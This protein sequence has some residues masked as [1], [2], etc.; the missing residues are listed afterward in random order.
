MLGVRR[1]SV[2]LVAHT[3][4]QAGIIKYTRGKTTILNLEGMQDAAC[5]CYATVIL[6]LMTQK[7]ARKEVAKIFGL[8]ELVEV[9]PRTPNDKR[10]KILMDLQK[11]ASEMWPSRNES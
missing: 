1:T 4:Q 3:L 8:V 2:T 9:H 11:K 6:H 7:D 5:E 10:L